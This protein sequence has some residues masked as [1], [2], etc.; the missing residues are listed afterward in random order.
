M[1]VMSRP[2]SDGMQEQNQ[3]PQALWMALE[4]I[5]CRFAGG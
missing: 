1:K 3:A 2:L 4:I 5:F